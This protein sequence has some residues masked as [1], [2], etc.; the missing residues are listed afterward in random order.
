M[1]TTKKNRW[2]AFIPNLLTLLN[3]SCGTVA[4]YFAFHHNF[5]VSIALMLAG[6]FFDFADGLV[7]RLLKI[8]G[9]LGKQ[10]DSLADLVTFG[11]LPG[12][13]VFA[14]QK[15][16]LFDRVGSYEQFSFLHW[17]IVFSAL[18]IPVLS[19]LRLAKFNIDTRQTD[20]FIGLPTPANAL[21]FAS[22]V[23]TIT[24]IQSSFVLFIGNPI[25]LG[26]ITLV[27]SL[28]LISEI[29]L[30]ALKFKTLKVKE[31]LFR[32]LFLLVSLVVIITMKFPGVAVAVL[33]YMLLS[34]VE[35][36]FRIRKTQLK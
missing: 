33:L 2:F 10:L 18:L 1:T 31:N 27:F 7:A 23:W 4:L 3:L 35:N 6:A 16:I 22:L 34:I 15:T 11:L 29:P 32:Y 8:T 5:D 20:S 26:A 12:V 30:F 13:M 17:S 24:N 21:F 9:E 25:V 28:L 14:T 19:A 36:V